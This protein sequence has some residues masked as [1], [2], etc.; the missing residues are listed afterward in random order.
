[1]SGI[2]IDIG[3]TYTKLCVLGEDGKLEALRAEGV[4]TGEMMRGRWMRLR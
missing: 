3:S 2:G 4:R 1:M